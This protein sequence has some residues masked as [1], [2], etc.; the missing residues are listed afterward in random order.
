MSGICL[1]KRRLVWCFIVALICGPWI[2]RAQTPKCE[3]LDSCY[4][5][6]LTNADSNRLIDQTPSAADTALI[7]DLARYGAQALPRLLELLANNNDALASLA[8]LGLEAMPP[9]DASYIP[10][11]EQALARKLKVQPVLTKINHPW[12]TELL[13][14]QYFIGRYYDKNLF[15]DQPLLPLLRRAAACPNPCS[16]LEEKFLAYYFVKIHELSAQLS[17][18]DQLSLLDSMA[19]NVDNGA[20]SIEVREANLRLLVVMVDQSP[21]FSTFKSRIEASCAHHSV[22]Q[23][24][25][26]WVAVIWRQPE[27]WRIIVSQLK[28]ATSRC[29]DVDRLL[30]ELASYGTQAKS[31]VS[32]VQRFL[33]DESALTRRQAAKTL[34]MIDPHVA[35]PLLTQQLSDPHDAFLSY[36]I[37]QL[38]GP[39]VVSPKVKKPNGSTPAASAA[40]LV[41]PLPPAL[42][43]QVRQALSDVKANYWYPPVRTAAAR[44]L[45]SPTQA[46]TLLDELVQNRSQKIAPADLA[47]VVCEL[48][49]VD[50]RQTVVNSLVDVTSSDATPVTLTYWADYKEFH[51]YEPATQDVAI[52]APWSGNPKMVEQTP[53]VMAR[54]GNG[55]LTGRERGEWGGELMYLPDNAPAQQLVSDNIFALVTLGKERL[56]IAGNAMFD[57]GRIYRITAKPASMPLQLQAERWFELPAYVDEWSLL[58]G[59]A[60]LLKSRDDGSFVLSADGSIQMAACR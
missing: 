8:V 52:G 18:A 33:R 45:E 26:Q 12:A 48:A 55:W 2:A 31:A 24:R 36:E 42:V 11:L 17:E 29:C 34:L 32:V 16:K 22:L 50:T 56:A 27:A 6:V 30:E 25:C 44:W 13:I 15:H 4:Y 60:L 59:D 7:A 14:Q 9:L 47:G 37:V 46:A 35:I 43:S 19:D 1:Y 58:A 41:A 51:N 20:L 57:Y 5:S 28:L 10:Q 38:F 53:D 3:S 23:Q 49:P 40:P 21:A 54:L 39:L